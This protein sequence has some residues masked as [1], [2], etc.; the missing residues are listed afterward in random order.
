MK[1]GVLTIAVIGA[2]MTALCLTACGGGTQVSSSA[3]SDAAS[4]GATSES[5]AGESAVDGA[6]Y[7][8]AG[9]DPIEA[10]VY[11]YMAENVSAY[12]DKADANIPTVTIVKVDDTNADE[13]LVYGDYWID[14]Y[15]ANGDTLE[16]VSG[17][18][19]PGVMHVVKDGDGY[20]VKAFGMIEDGTD[21][22]SSAKELFGEN[23][24]AFIKVYSDSDTSDELR[25]AAV[26]NYIKLNDLDFTQYQALGQEPVKL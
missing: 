12:F 11:K 20:T 10:A 1:K 9:D 17:G 15:N 23:Y 2:L 7:G 21:F 24:D 16:C 13:V 22:D 4:S 14:N 6:A 19:F 8:Y 18:H 5:T 25:K 26:V 3:S